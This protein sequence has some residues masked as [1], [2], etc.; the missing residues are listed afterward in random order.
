MQA[1]NHWILHKYPYFASTPWRIQRENFSY[2]TVRVI[3]RDHY[4][5][6]STFQF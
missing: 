2:L 1:R 3:Q 6:V 5:D 4:K